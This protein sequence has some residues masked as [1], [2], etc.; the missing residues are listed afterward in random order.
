MK[1]GSVY[2]QFSAVILR[3]YCVWR[4]HSFCSRNNNS[5]NYV[6]YRIRDMER[7]QYL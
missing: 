6:V 4:V 2:F 3:K 5:F 1:T 7:Y